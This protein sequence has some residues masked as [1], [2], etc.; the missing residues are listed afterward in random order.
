M[1][2]LS[3]EIAGN[4]RSS[5]D[6][7][8]NSTLVLVGRRR[9]S[10]RPHL[11]VQ[12]TRFPLRQPRK[13]VLLPSPYS[14]GVVPDPY[15]GED[16]SDCAHFLARQSKLIGEIIKNCVGESIA[17]QDRNSSKKQ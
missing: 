6:N 3:R 10:E 17:G 16:S 15:R 12:L 1:T 8:H 11:T 14:P 13:S 2:V 5:P 9:R 4:Y 7:R